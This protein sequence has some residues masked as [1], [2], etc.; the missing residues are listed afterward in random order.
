MKN[1]MKAILKILIG[2]ILTDIAFGMIILPQSFAAGGITGLSVILHKVIPLS[3]SVLVFICNVVLFVLGYL[4]VGKEFVFK[5]LFV[6]ILFPIGL[7]LCQKYNFLSQMKSDPLMSAVLAGIILGVGSGLVLSGD[8]STGGFDIIGVILHKYFKIPVSAVMNVCDCTV[9]LIQAVKNPFMKNIY[10][11]VVIMVCTF[12]VNKVLSYGQ[13]QCEIMIMSKNFEKIRKRIFKEADVGLT[14]LK[15]ES[16]YLR[17]EMEV[18]MIVT[19]YDKI[20]LIKKIAVEEDPTSFVFVNDVHSVIG[21][22][23]TLSRE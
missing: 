10:G 9:L 8:G 22:G 5:T 14:L 1:K 18:L 23:Y 2:V 19:R 6:S 11:I 12:A 17:K 4:F 7:D 3:I 15:A 20:S 21:K 16:G 13:S